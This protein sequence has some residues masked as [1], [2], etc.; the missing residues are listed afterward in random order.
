MALTTWQEQLKAATPAYQRYKLNVITK[1]AHDVVFSTEECN[2]DDTQ[3]YAFKPSIPPDFRLCAHCA[4]NIE[5]AVQHGFDEPVSKIWLLS[6][7][8]ITEADARAELA[9]KAPNPAV[10]APGHVGAESERNPT[11]GDGGGAPMGD[12][13]VDSMGLAQTTAPQIEAPESTP[14][15]ATAYVMRGLVPFTHGGYSLTVETP[16]SSNIV[17]LTWLAGGELTMMPYQFSEGT[18]ALLVEFKGGTRY[19]YEDVGYGTFVSLWTAPRV[20]VAF[21]ALVKKAGNAYRQLEV[22]ELRGPPVTPYDGAGEEEA[23]IAAV[24]QA[25]KGFI[26]PPKR[27]RRN[28]TKGESELTPAQIAERDAKERDM[29]ERLKDDTMPEV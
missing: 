1:V 11:R 23:V 12:I 19:L 24:V 3:T 25:G 4:A 27:G 10:N 15:A 28:P 2:L 17:S 13:G 26:E 18:A 20:G 6:R 7:D 22:D 5:R 16:D 8:R 29:Q 21:D 14:A 9:H